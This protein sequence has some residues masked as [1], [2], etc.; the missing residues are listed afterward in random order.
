MIFTRSIRQYRT[1]TL[2]SPPVR[3][4]VRINKILFKQTN[5]LFRLP[6]YCHKSLGFGLQRPVYC[7]IVLKAMYVCNIIDY[8]GCQNCILYNH[9]LL[10]IWRLPSTG[11]HFV[12]SVYSPLSMREMSSA[13][14]FSISIF[15]YL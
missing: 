1:A 12:S 9:T 5:H 4:D 8:S 11:G 10:Y 6:A 15:L 14:Y 2:A 3:M 13:S 7:S